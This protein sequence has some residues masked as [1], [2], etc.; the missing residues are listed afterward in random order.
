M[1]PVSRVL[2]AQTVAASASAGPGWGRPQVAGGADPQAQLHAAAKE[3]EGL[4][5]AQMLRDARESS[6]AEGLFDSSQTR[7]FQSMLDTEVAR[8]AAG[9]LDLGI[10]RALVVQLGPRAGVGG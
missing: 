4:F 3:F 2:P 7:T 10:A 1:I 6:L 5:L 8:G 9:A